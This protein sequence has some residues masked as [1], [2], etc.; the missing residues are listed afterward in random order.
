[1]TGRAQRRRPPGAPD[2]SGRR[3][4]PT[5]RV[6]FLYS[7][8]DLAGTYIAVHR[9]QTA[10]EWLMARFT[11]IG[12]TVALAACS[13]QDDRTRSMTADVEVIDSDGDGSYDGI[14]VDGD[15][16]ADI[17]FGEGLCDHPAVDQDDDGRPDG[18]D[19]DCDGEVEIAWCEEPLID[20]DADGVPDG[21]DLDCDSAADVDLG[22]DHPE[23]DQGP[24]DCTPSTIDDDADG[25][26]D[27]IDL[28]CDGTG[29][30]PM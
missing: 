5:I 28:D 8:A 24:P 11:F 15:G 29:D 2:S 23:P 1:M 9:R 26:P 19:F 21:I 27:G 20:D 12:L 22:A 10:K 6:Q 13:G 30:A 18:L 3:N 17:H 14:D 25:R 4:Y 16:E 7:C